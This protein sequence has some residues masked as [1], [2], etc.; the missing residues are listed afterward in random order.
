[1]WLCGV[2]ADIKLAPLD[3]SYDASTDNLVIKWTDAGT[4]PPVSSLD[5]MLIVLMTGPNTLIHPIT[6]LEQDMTAAQI[7]KG[8]ISIPLS[9]V[10]AL[11]SNGEYFLQVNT[12]MGSLQAMYY[13][14]R[15]KLTGMTGSYD[16]TGSGDPPTGSAMV[17]P[18]SVVSSLNKTP[19][20]S[21]TGIV[22]YAPMQMQPGTTVT[23]AFVMS[24]RFPTSA[25]TYFTTARPNPSVL[26][27]ITPGWSYT[28]TTHTN[29][30]PTMPSPTAY[31]TAS[32]EQASSIAAKSSSK[33]KRW[34]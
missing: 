19:Y 26:T 9:T 28:F 2:Y 15:F 11:G 33:K 17:P 10:A 29:F 1:M 23:K 21:Q 25:V 7:A 18:P 14:N 8:S 24:R 5:K 22:K 16:A 4:F 31:R 12:F 30:A 32:A 34:A 6:T 20:Q 27:T 13:S 3:T